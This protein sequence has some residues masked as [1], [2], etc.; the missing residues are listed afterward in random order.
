MSEQEM[1]AEVAAPVQ[2]D[3]QSTPSEPATSSE[4]MIPQSQVNKIVGREVHDAREKTRQSLTKEFEQKQSQMSQQSHGSNSS[5]GGMIQ[6]SQEQLKEMISTIASEKAQ[7]KLAEQ[8]EMQVE[9]WRQEQGN[10]IANAWEEKMSLGK[11]KYPDFDSVVGEVDFRTIPQ[12]VLLTT[13]LDNTADVVY[14]LLNNPHKIASVLTNYAVNQGLARK[15]IK[16]ISDSIR[17]NQSAQKSPHVPEPL[18]PISPSTVGTDNGN[19]GVKD[20]RAQPWLR[21]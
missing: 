7:E 19:M 6:V 8:R 10:K 11:E 12:I 17:M 4:R 21:A 2:S 16:Q 1:N 3:V 14:D 5:M 20:Y 15:Q 13:E 9:Q 18:K